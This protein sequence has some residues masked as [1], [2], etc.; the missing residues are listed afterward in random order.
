MNSPFIFDY[1][2]PQN[3]QENTQ[4]PAVFLLHGMGSN[5]KDLPGLLNN[6]HEPC[7]IFSL[8]GPII[9]AP[10]YAFFTIEEF[11]KPDR[12]VF[13]KIV[14]HIKAFIEEAI[15][16]YAIDSTKI[17]L[18]GFSQ[19]AILTQTLSLI[20]GSDKL[21][22]AVVLSGYLPQHVKD[23]YGKESVAGLPMLITHGKMD[24]VL[25][26]QWGENSRDFFKHQKALVNYMEFDDG[27]GVTQAVQ[28]EIIRFLSHH[29]QINS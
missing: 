9:Q 25:P 7:H 24:Y 3:A 22:G 13:D 2:A 6:L 18:L 8:Q 5:E 15:E 29:M 19:G 4:Y 23:E 26:L 20:L 12:L 17:F 28:T 10:G 21:A 14:L 11:G 27:H 16:E 1:T